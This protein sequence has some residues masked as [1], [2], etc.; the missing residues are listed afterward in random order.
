MLSTWCET[1]VNP[2]R[3]QVDVYTGQGVGGGVLGNRFDIVHAVWRVL[4][5]CCNVTFM[6]QG[7]PDMR[8]PVEHPTL[9][10][11]HSSPGYQQTSC[12]NKLSWQYQEEKGS[13][14]FQ[15]Y[16]NFA[17]EAQPWGNYLWGKVDSVKGNYAVNLKSIEGVMDDDGKVSLG[18][19]ILSCY[20]SL[21]DMNSTESAFWSRQKLWQLII[22]NYS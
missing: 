21:T 2:A 12:H 7:T 22:T 1:F 20:E 6:I 8:H 17:G 19:I 10:W 13:L 18:I 11:G 3:F 4:S 5:S 16:P 14:L 9:C 15:L